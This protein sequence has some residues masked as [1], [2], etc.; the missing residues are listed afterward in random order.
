MKHNRQGQ[1]PVPVQEPQIVATIENQLA[2]LEVDSLGRC[3]ALV[4]KRSGRNLIATP[5]PLATVSVQGRVLDHAACSHAGGRFSL[6]FGDGEAV[7]VIECVVKDRYMTFTLIS[8]AGDG[9]ESVT[10]LWLTVQRGKYSSPTS[11][12]IVGDDWSVCL[13]ELNLQTQV[14][15]GGNPYGLRASCSAQHGIAGGR[16]GLVVAPPELLIPA[17]QDMVKGEGVPYSPLGGPWALGAEEVR[18]SYLYATV[19]EKD[20]DHFIDLARRGGFSHLHY[21]HWYKSRGHN[22][23]LLGLFPHGLEGMKATVFKVHAAG[24]KAGMHTL[25]GCIQ[26][27]DPWV[28]PVPDKRLFADATYVLAADMDEKTDAIQ[29]TE[30]PQHTAIHGSLPGRSNAIRIG[31]ELIQYDYADISHT[32][33]F[34]FL[35]CTRGA[36]GTKPAA[37]VKNDRVD[38]L[39][40]RYGAFFPD[41]RSTLVN[42][43]ADAIARVYN[44]CGFD[45]LY[46]DGAEGMGTRHAIQTMRDAIYKR[47]DHPAII[48]A[49]EWGHW[50]WYFHSR[51]GAMDVPLWGVKSFVDWRCTNIAFFRQGALLQAQLGWWFIFGPGVSRAEVPD[52]MEYFSCKALAFDVP[53]STIICGSPAVQANDRMLEYITMA[54][55]YER[56]RLANYF[57]ETVKEQLRQPGKDFHLVQRD[58]GEWRLLPADYQ[59]HKVTG[60]DDGTTNWEVVNPFSEQPLRMRLEALHAVVPCDAPDAMVIADFAEP[61]RFTLRSTASDVTQAVARSTDQ[62]RGGDASL[63]LTATNNRSVRKGAWTRVGMPFTPYLDIKQNEA[64]G[65]WVFGDGKGEVLNVQL[66]SPR[67]Y[68]NALSE[69]HIKID[70][71]GW[72]YFEL[73]L[74]ERDAGKFKD[75]EWPYFD[76]QALFMNS[77]DRQHISEL[78]LYLNNL[79]PKDSVS[80]FVGPVRALRCTDRTS[81]AN[82]V[83]TVNGVPLALPVTLQSG[84]YVEFDSA[85]D[86]RV[87]NEH[88]ALVERL[89][90]PG[91]IPVLNAGANRVSF[92]CTGSAGFSARADVTV[93]SFGSPLD[94]R[95]PAA[96]VKWDLLRDEYESPR[97]VTTLDGRDNAWS[98]I[99]RKDV[100]AA[101]IGVEIDVLQI[102]ATGETMRSPQLVIGTQRLVFPV[103]VSAG[104][105]IVLDGQG[106]CRLHRQAA[107]EPE[108]IQVQGAPAT[109]KSGRT[110]VVFSFSTDSP[111]PFRAAVSLIKHYR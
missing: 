2:R 19:S 53:S 65:V 93:I 25:T 4:D 107:L 28:T 16:A 55:R 71:T 26:H 10:F 5:A 43:V 29:T 44:E 84:D 34:G 70:F 100:K 72:R 89:C 47:L 1:A 17:L 80:V 103:D 98:V 23:P 96:V 36:F 32:P 52:E 40:Q 6:R 49:S 74:R 63:C 105:R 24:L 38:R 14:D 73:L 45:Q 99:C 82:P 50:S 104:D 30:N 39:R 21:D 106:R 13:R 69:H 9:L 51:I 66:V 77:L 86:G 8:A 68:T 90:L 15:V 61:E 110:G 111:P 62:V 101:S 92:A 81:L 83:V 60:F 87:Y 94:G 109:L 95:S 56:L 7:A 41:D 67:V 78:N 64:L 27:S 54:G 58:D 108:L 11:G 59:M 12:A 102:G 57:P 75:Y 88:G 97:L 31:D 35:K 20:A 91:K 42:E 3:T 46:M 22:E 76:H 33:P 85:S 37:H 18:G 79:P 48:E